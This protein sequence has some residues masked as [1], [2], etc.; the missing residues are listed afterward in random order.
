MTLEQLEKIITTMRQNGACQDANV[1][2][3]PVQARVL[4]DMR[5]VIERKCPF[6]AGD[7][8]QQIKAFS[9]YS[10][11]TESELGL[12]TCVLEPT[13]RP[14]AGRGDDRVSQREDMVILLLIHSKWVEFA[15]ESWRFQKYEGP[16][17]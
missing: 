7:L 12:V 9:A 2:P 13:L 8:V 1:R 17:A 6:A 14:A 16:I 10:H 15:V 4:A 3:L 5:A 11:P